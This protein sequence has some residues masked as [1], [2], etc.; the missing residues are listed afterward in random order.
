MGTSSTFDISQANPVLKARYS[1][2]GVAKLGYPDMP[3]LAT[4]PKNKDLGGLSY[5]W[6]IRTAPTQTV[7]TKFANS[8]ASDANA[9]SVTTYKQFVASNPAHYN[10]YGTAN[11]TGDAI[12][13]AKGD[14]DRLIDIMTGEIDNTLYTMQRELERFIIGNGG[15]ALGQIGSGVGTTTITLTDITTITRFEVGMS[16]QVGTDD[17]SVNPFGGLRVG[18]GFIKSIDRDLGTL[19]VSAMIGGAAV[20]WSTEFTAA[21]N[22]DYIFRYGDY[23]TV[24]GVLTSAPGFAGFLP[25]TAPTSTLFFGVDRTVDATRLAGVRFAGAG[26][27][28]EETLISCAMRLGREQAKPDTCFMNPLDVD[29]LVRALGSRVV[30]DRAGVKSFDQ[31][32]IGFKS[33]NIVGPRG[34]IK[35]VACSTVPKGTFYMLQLNTWTLMSIGRAPRQINEDGQ[36]LL[37]VQNSD[38]YEARF[39]SRYLITC[40]APGWNAVGTF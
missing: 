10:H 21:A 11:I 26:N 13:T 38:A 20:A 25:A 23:P 5:A 31:P 8:Q 30:Y 15:S 19:Q 9:G 36:M 28:Y 37:R 14:E 6:A 39:V 7:S 17:G 16:I 24:N 27:A 33:V 22:N 32:D 34:D 1:D 3:V 4:I 29:P 40:S 35:V 2:K 18:N 12:D